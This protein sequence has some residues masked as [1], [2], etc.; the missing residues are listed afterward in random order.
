MHGRMADFRR[1]KL[2]RT[3]QGSNFLGE[4]FSNTDNERD[5]I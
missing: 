3:N 2:P 4:I 1:K 5:P